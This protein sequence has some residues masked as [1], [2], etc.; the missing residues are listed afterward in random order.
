[1][2]LIY[3]TK[4]E[5]ISE[6]GDKSV[7]FKRWTAKEER[8][9]LT[10]LENQKEEFTDKTVYDILIMPCIEDKNIVLSSSQQKKV[11]IDIRIESISKYLEDERTCKSCGETYEIK[12]EIKDFMKYVPSKFE[13]VEI[14][15]IKFYL[16][17]IKSNKDKEI[18]KISDGIINY[19][20]NDFLL[21]INAIE[22]NGEINDNL[23][24]K[25]LQKFMDSLPSYIFDE[26]FDK[27]KDMVDDL[28]MDCEC[29]CPSCGNK[30]VVDYTNIPNLLWA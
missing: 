2:A 25:E 12:K 29:E 10:A 15:D 23:K 1:M 26:V 27:Y 8:R 11:L 24:F 13:T 6:L 18:L 19:V 28:E 14:E 16:G 22:L 7:K 9:Y 4:Y 20:F 21:H 5:F 17:E 3:E 30:E